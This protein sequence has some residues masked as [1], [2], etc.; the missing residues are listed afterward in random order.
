MARFVAQHAPESFQPL[1]DELTQHTLATNYDR[2]MAGTGKSQAFGVIR[3]WSYRPWL[4]R[5]TWM[6]PRL[7]QL[8]QE[9]GAAHLPAGFT[10]DAIQVNV[11][12]QSKAHKDKGNLGD[13][14]IVGFGDYTGGELNVSEAAHDIRHRGHLF[15][16]A[17]EWHW[18]SPWQGTRYSLVF[19]SI[20]W[21]AKFPR[22]S[23]AARQVEDGLEITDEYDHSITVLDQRGRLV[24]TVQEG[25][26]MPWRG[27]VTARGQPSRMPV[28]APP[29]SVSDA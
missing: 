4:S 22:Y 29:P 10:Y 16:G 8:L 23:V 15:N 12:F 14:Y 24:R 20:E 1:I 26:P 9:W 3:R 19:F 11:D 7:W 25:Q 2:A 18:T 17:R 27:R 28:P 21:P 6:R 13:S 5:N